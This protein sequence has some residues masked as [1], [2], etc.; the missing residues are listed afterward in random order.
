MNSSSSSNTLFFESS[1]F[2]GNTASVSAP[3]LL[4]NQGSYDP[5]ISSCN[6]FENSFP[7]TGTV[8]N[9]EGFQ[10]D[11]LLTGNT[12]L[13]S[14]FLADDSHGLVDPLDWD[15]HL[16]VGSPLI[17]SGVGTDSDGGPADIGMFGG[18]AQ[19]DLDGDGY[20]LWWQPGPYDSAT[21]PGLGL[22]CDDSDP[23]LY[24]GSGC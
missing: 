22:D 10:A 1:D 3:G 19:W 16:Q 9:F 20:I 11:P 18:N 7:F 21:Y 12:S 24:P 17:D 13:D 2:S 6:A 4:N 15:L 5:G 8:V 14:Q 23:S